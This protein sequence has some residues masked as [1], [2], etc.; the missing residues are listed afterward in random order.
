[1][2]HSM[3]NISY[4]NITKNP[5]LKGELHLADEVEI[6]LIDNNNVCIE[7]GACQSGVKYCSNLGNNNFELEAKVEEEQAGFENVTLD[8]AAELEGTQGNDN[9]SA[10]VAAAVSDASNANASDSSPAVASASSSSSF[11][12]NINNKNMNTNPTLINSNTL[13]TSTTA[14]KGDDEFDTSGCWVSIYGYPCCEGNDLKRVYAEDNDGKWGYNFTKKAWC[15]ISSYEEISNKFAAQSKNSATGEECWSL[16]LGY[17]CCIGCTV[18]S[19]TSQG[20]WGVEHN[21]W[22]GI[23]SYCSV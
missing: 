2:N 1:M 6:C 18:Y 19:V 11:L 10:A 8:D 13:L 12:N 20:S 22:C 3:F 5:N 17:S 4:S 7:G 16:E 15:G 21:H 14:P 9:P 23:P